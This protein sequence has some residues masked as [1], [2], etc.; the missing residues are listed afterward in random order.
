MQVLEEMQNGDV[1]LYC[2]VGNH[3]HK[4]GRAR[5]FEYLD[6]LGSNETGV[7]GF[8]S[9]L[10][11]RQWTKGDIF[12]Y[13]N[14]REN[15][16]IY[17]TGQIAGGTIFFRKCE[18][19]VHLV[20]KWRQS[21]MDCF[22]LYDQ[23]TFNSANLDGFIANRGEQSTLSILAKLHDA[24][25]VST[26]DLKQFPITVVRD[27]E[28]DYSVEIP[29]VIMQMNLFAN[30]AKIE[31]KKIIIWGAGQGGVKTLELLEHC[32]IKIHAFMDSSSEKIGTSLKGLPVFSSEILNEDSL[33]NRRHCSIF[34]A[35]SGGYTQIGQQLK[36][37]GWREGI[38]FFIIPA[39]V[40]TYS[41]FLDKM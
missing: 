21:F 17:N 8:Q 30:T 36:K 26:S 1:L 41:S 14:C 23:D 5:L 33:L 35:S 19:C 6:I 9:K 16:E 27:K 3:L 18:K 15:P 40:F 31:N 37:T 22:E 34:V 24:A 39:S 2:D 4:Y 28:Y 11:E 29:K 20:K 12:D 10:L 13:F 25:V 32:G 38:D 7:L